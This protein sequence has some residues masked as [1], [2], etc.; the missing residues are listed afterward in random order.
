MV[1]IAPAY[2]R[3]GAGGSGDALFSAKYALTREWCG[4]VG[5]GKNGGLL[6]VRFRVSRGSI[7]KRVMA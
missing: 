1:G 3:W 4:A 2:A 5:T 7:V 6:P